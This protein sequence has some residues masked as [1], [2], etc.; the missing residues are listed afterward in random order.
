MQRFYGAFAKPLLNTDWA[1]ASDKWLLKHR[2][3]RTVFNGNIN[4]IPSDLP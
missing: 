2:K 3:P 1:L 4:S